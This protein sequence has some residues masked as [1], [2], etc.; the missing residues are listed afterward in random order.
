M[1]VLALKLKHLLL[2]GIEARKTIGNL[3]VLKTDT[4]KQVL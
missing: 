3:T 1:R 2:A 4:G